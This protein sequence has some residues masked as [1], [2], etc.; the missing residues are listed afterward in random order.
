MYKT[1]EQILK[2]LREKC[3][4]NVYDDD[5]YDIIIETID[6]E[7]EVI[8]NESCNTGYELIAYEN[9][10]NSTCFCFGA[11]KKGIITDVWY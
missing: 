5:M 3:I 10:E 7:N 6:S 2:E 9:K 8:I 11:N 1:D 4:G